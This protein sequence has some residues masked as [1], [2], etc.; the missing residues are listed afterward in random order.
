MGY[1]WST[2]DELFAADLNAAIAYGL[3]AS[4]TLVSD[5]APAG[6][7][8]NVLWWDSRGTGLYIRYNDGNSSQWVATQSQNTLTDAPSDGNTYGRLNS[9]WAPLNGTWLPLAGGTLSG[10]LTLSGNA[11]N[12]LH[13]V[14][15]QQLN[16]AV[17]GGPFLP[18]TGGTVTGPLNV[19]ATGGN[20]VRSAQ[21]RFADVVNVKDYGATGAGA[22]SDTAAIQAAAAA[23]PASGGT[24]YIPAGTYL[25]TGTVTLKS[26]TQVRGDGPGTMLL[27]GSAWSTGGGFFIN[28]NSAATTL[29]DSNIVI[30][31]LVLDFGTSGKTG[32]TH[33]IDLVY[34]HGVK[35]LHVVFQCRGAGDATAIRGCYDSD[36]D[37]CSAYSFVNCAYD[38]WTNPQKARVVNCYAETAVSAQ[39]IN[40][41]PENTTPGTSAGN[42]A[43][44]FV[45][46]NNQFV[47]TGATAIPMQLEPLETGTSVV[48][49]TVSNNQFTNC[50]LLLRGNTSNAVV[51]DNVFLNNAGGSEVITSYTNLGG[52]P[53]NISVTGNVII[54]PDTSAGNIAVIRLTGNNSTIVGNQ[55]SGINYTANGISTA[56]GT[57]LVQGNSVSNQAITTTS[58]GFSLQVPDTTTLGGNARGAGAVDLQTSRTAATQV[59]SGIAALAAGQNNIA[60]GN[61]SVAF[62]LTNTVSGTGSFAA[63]GSNVVSATQYAAALGFGNTVA[64][65]FGVGLGH[66]AYDVG[67]LGSIAFTSGQRSAAGDVQMGMQT[68]RCN[69]SS[70]TPVV[71]TADGLAPGA[72]NV[73]NTGP[74]RCCNLKIRVV[75]RNSTSN[76]GACWVADNALLMQIGS[77]ATQ[78]LS[79]VTFTSGGTFGSPVGWSVA[80]AADT[81]NGG[82]AVSCTGTAADTIRWVVF[83]ESVEAQ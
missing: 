35:V 36:V 6:A 37:G 53:A 21:N 52:T 51:A 79:P 58:G 19:T 80:A 60:S 45:L 71:A 13:A 32:S 28:Q 22:V 61:R 57:G 70:T 69:T 55:I 59:A 15:L 41:N 48:N 7:L 81:V 76:Q 78:T 83:I 33:A 18:L 23:I 72:A 8:D 63:G 34:V 40:F 1:P 75:A 27:G 67:R 9:T 16:A 2:G 17:A 50:E 42:V 5:T 39:F 64:G 73:F 20:T 44:G 74:N 77:A 12:P 3:S 62:G 56:A 26:N 82:I 43:N 54:N 31:D 49:V 68:L 66:G 38:H 47:C 25:T 30:R 46:S 10:P 4:I 14:P 11:V 29:T 24:L 65:Q